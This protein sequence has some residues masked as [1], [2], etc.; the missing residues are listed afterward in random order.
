MFFD[1]EPTKPVG[2]LKPTSIQTTKVKLEIK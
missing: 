2:L 1:T